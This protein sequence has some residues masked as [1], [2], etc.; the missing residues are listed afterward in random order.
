MRGA[1]R[2]DRSSLRVIGVRHV[3]LGTPFR[4]TPNVLPP[5]CTPPS[6]GLLCAA[7]MVLWRPHV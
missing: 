6:R 7:G 4:R 1:I 5:L 2:A 3:F